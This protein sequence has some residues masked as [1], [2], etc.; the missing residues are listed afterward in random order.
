M[1]P[2][3]VPMLHGPG[4]RKNR[5]PGARPP[6]HLRTCTQEEASQRTSNRLGP[7][8][9]CCR[10]KEHRK[11]I[12]LIRPR[13]SEAEQ[14]DQRDYGEVPNLGVQSLLSP[15]PSDQVIAGL[16]ICA[17]ARL[18]ESRGIDLDPSIDTGALPSISVMTPC[19]TTLAGSH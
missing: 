15:L 17:V 19:H 18:P 9:G 16:K 13:Q 3:V 11:K 6:A 8:D 10:R 5:L 4:G 12:R 14:G 1:P 2:M 7:S